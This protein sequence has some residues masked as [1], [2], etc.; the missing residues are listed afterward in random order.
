MFRVSKIPY[1]LA[2]GVLG[3][4]I[5]FN[6]RSY[7]CGPSSR[8][9]KLV[10]LWLHVPTVMCSTLHI[11]NSTAKYCTLVHGS[12]SPAMQISVAA[13]IFTECSRN[14]YTISRLPHFTG[15]PTRYPFA[16]VL[17]PPHCTIKRNVTKLIILF[18]L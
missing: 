17:F 16:S 8:N 9:A 5:H 7:V 1:L 2:P 18:S 10:H 12:F 6:S 11:G 15:W 14:R 13:L 3:V 4:D